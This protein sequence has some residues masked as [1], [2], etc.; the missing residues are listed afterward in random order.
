ML[1]RLLTAMIT[2]FKPGGDVDYR[3]A[4]R[5]AESLVD[6]GNEGLVLSGTTG[7]SPALETKEKLRLFEV[8]KSAL[9]DR[10]TIVA[11]TGGNNTHHSIELTSEAS[12]CGVDAILAVVPYY[13]KPTQDGMLLHFGAIA[14]ST[15]LPIIV[16]NVPSRTGANMLPATLRTLQDRHRNIAGVKD[17]TGDLAQMTAILRERREGFLFYCGDDHLFLPVLALGGDGLVGVASHLCAPQFREMM[18][19]FESGDVRRAGMIHRE[20]SPLFAAL[21]ATT[22]PIPVKWAMAQLGW[23]VGPCRSPLGA[24][25]EE[26]KPRLAGFLEAYRTAPAAV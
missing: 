21:F 25:P 9:G 13:N 26:L 10:A 22:S 11:G 20:L 14:D 6:A 8:V 1:G 15:A 7:E 18:R 19:A 16:Y 2:P 5:L 24:M 23:H 4:V 17:S 12:K 3:E